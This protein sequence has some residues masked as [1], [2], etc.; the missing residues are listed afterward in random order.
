MATA[1][2]PAEGSAAREAWELL[3]T[4]F[5]GNRAHLLAATAAYDLS[6]MQAHVLRLL[7]PD[8]PVPMSALA[9]QLCCDAS[10]VT[11]IVDRLEARGFVERRRDPHDGRVRALALTGSGA[12]LRAAVHAKLREPPPVIAGL[13]EEDQRALADLLRRALEAQ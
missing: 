9:G 11:G 2:A 4:L 3:F 10:N 8:R 1:E 6:P 13:D 5:Q 12:V 7:E